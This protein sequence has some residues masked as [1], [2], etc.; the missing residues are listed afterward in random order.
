[1]YAFNLES[2]LDLCAV[3]LFGLRGHL[4]FYI[5]P[6]RTYL[7]PTAGFETNPVC[8]ASDRFCFS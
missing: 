3:M 1:M 2:I 7:Y 4:L 6:V 8:Y 5:F